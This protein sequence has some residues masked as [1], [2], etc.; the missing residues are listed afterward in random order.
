V[1]EKKTQP[2]YK[3]QRFLLAL[4]QQLASGITS[5]DLQKLVFLHTMENNVDFYEFIPYKFGAYSFQLAED[6]DILRRDG[7][8]SEDVMHIKAIGD[9]PKGPFLRVADERGDRLIR[10]VY[11]EY[12]YYAINSEITG[13]LF[14]KEEAERF[15]KE[16]QKYIITDKVLFTI[17]YEGLSIEAFINALINNGIQLLCDVRKNPLSRKFG[18][19]KGK[20]E[21]ITKTVNIK[22]ANI[23]ELGI[24]IDKRSSLC[25]AADYQNLFR[26]YTDTLPMLKKY[27]DWLYSQLSSSYRIALMC[28]EKNAIMCHRHIIADHM[29]NNYGIRS[30]EL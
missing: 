30:I 20:L 9:Y 23:P 18:F 14:D 4:I 12:P 27:L 29:V 24:D 13:R 21:H 8:L 10:K 5:T 1:N 2:T 6:V 19:S 17:G 11:R 15:N 3:R 25:S 22:Y 7:Y 28:Y 26:G 16:K